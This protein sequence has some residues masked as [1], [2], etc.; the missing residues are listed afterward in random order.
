MDV[1]PYDDILVATNNRTFGAWQD[2]GDLKTKLVEKDLWSEFVGYSYPKW[3]D[4]LGGSSRGIGGH[5]AW[6]I[7]I[8]RIPLIWEFLAS[9]GEIK[10]GNDERY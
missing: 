9:V 10:E 8:A 6:L 3:K 4:E 5:T 2:F 7:D 1:V